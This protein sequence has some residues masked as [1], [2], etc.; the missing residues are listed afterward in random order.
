MRIEIGYNKE[1][2]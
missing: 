1:Q 2:I